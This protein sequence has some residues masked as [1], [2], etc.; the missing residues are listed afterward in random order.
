MF[1][2]DTRIDA[3]YFKLL[4]KARTSTT[5]RIFVP[6]IYSNNRL[7]SPCILKRNHSTTLFD[8]QEAALSYDGEEITAINSCMA[9]D[10]SLFNEYRYDENIFLDGIDHNFLMQMKQKGEHI[11]VFP[12][13]CNHDFSGDSK[14]PQKSAMVRF[15]IYAKDYRYILRENIGDYLTLLGRR[16][17]HLTVQYRSLAFIRIFFRTLVQ[18]V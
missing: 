16:T 1:D 6:L 14:P 2:D 5:N 15:S 4:R 7:L 8:S 17:M 18:K 13:Q 3:E 12:Y 9:L 11:T 10:L